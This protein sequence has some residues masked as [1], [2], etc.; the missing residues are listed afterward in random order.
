ML[1]ED[2]SRRKRACTSSESGTLPKLFV[3]LIGKVLDH[4]NNPADVLSLLSTCQFLLHLYSSHYFAMI[5][6][7]KFIDDVLSVTGIEGIHVLCVWTTIHT[8]PPKQVNVDFD[9]DLTVSRK[10]MEGLVRFFT[11][12]ISS[13]NPFLHHLSLSLPQ[14]IDAMSLTCLLRTVSTWTIHICSKR[15]SLNKPSNCW[16]Y[17][18]VC[19]VPP[20]L[21]HFHAYVG[22]Q[23][24]DTLLFGFSAFLACRQKTVL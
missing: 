6:G 17:D 8:S 22:H 16:I 15:Y 5:N 14:T 23:Y 21:Q 19:D 11:S 2:G 7:F 20:A 9:D 1:P 13:P 4:L 3:E 10:E 18:I 24:Y 12:F